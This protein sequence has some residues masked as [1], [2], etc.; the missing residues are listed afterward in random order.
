MA[1]A[2]DPGNAGVHSS[3]YR[4][5]PNLRPQRLIADR[6]SSA[7]MVSSFATN[8]GP[9]HRNRT[10][11]GAFSQPERCAREKLSASV[12]LI[13]TSGASDDKMKRQSSLSVASPDIPFPS[14]NPGAS[15]LLSALEFLFGGFIVIGHNV[16]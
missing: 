5:W 9:V 11:S 13:E 7:E 4:H 15:R 2:A 16:F 8:S 1:D 14:A 12:N 3:P 10:A 6:I